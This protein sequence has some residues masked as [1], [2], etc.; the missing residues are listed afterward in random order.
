MNTSYPIED[1]IYRLPKVTWNDG[2]GVCVDA[3]SLLSR[4]DDNSVDVVFLDPPFNLR[5]QYGDSDRSK[6]NQD[7][8]KYAE[9]IQTVIDSSIRVL[10]PG[11]A[12]YCYHV[13][14]HA[15]AISSYLTGR[16]EFRHWIAVAMKNN[17]ARGQYLYPA[18]YALLYYTKGAPAHFERPKIPVALCRGCG[19]T[20]KDYGGYVQYVRD[21]INLSD[22]WDDLSPVRHKNKKNRHANEMPLAIPQRALDISGSEGGLV[23][24]PFMGS[25]TTAI[26]AVQKGMKFVGGDREL[27]SL[28]VLSMRLEKLSCKCEHAVAKS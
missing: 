6:D 24:D 11:G 22:V 3:C 26:A 4:I 1:S 13:P 14:K 10:K 17:F 28:D 21:G 23:V 25:G 16:L 20:V 5:K 27:S 12:L 7:P 18:H 19:E 2:I 9:F 15:V 8:S